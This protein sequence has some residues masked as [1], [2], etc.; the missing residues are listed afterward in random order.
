MRSENPFLKNNGC[1]CP[2]FI[3]FI[4]GKG[5][6][7]NE[8]DPSVFWQ[9][10]VI[11][12]L[13]PQWVHLLLPPLEQKMKGRESFSLWPHGFLWDRSVQPDTEQSSFASPQAS[14]WCPPLCLKK[15]KSGSLKRDGGYQEE[16]VPWPQR[17]CSEGKII[18]LIRVLNIMRISH[19]NSTIFGGAEWLSYSSDSSLGVESEDDKEGHLSPRRHSCSI[20][21]D[22]REQKN[23]SNWKKGEGEGK[24]ARHTHPGSRG[25]SHTWGLHPLEMT[26]IDP[27][28]DIPFFWK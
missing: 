24:C 16:W 28:R 18:Y 27:S 15:K 8:K 1:W 14:C 26:R 25:S 22:R 21:Q 5:D 7:W 9:E 20:R 6:G 19:I 11:R 4:G 23:K 3:A 12:G 10:D 13:Q 17:H 2:S